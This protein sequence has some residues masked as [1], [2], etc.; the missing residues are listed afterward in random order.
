M[1]AKPKALIVLPELPYPTAGGG[2]LRSASLVEYL[3]ERYQLDAVTFWEEG[4]ARPND[5]RLG[6]LCRR[7]RTIT[8]PR[9]PRSVAPRAA[10]NFGRLWRGVPPL[11]D[12]FAGFEDAIS[13]FLGS[14]T[15]AVSLAEH[16]WCASYGDVLDARSERT[17]LDLHNIESV[18]HERCGESEQWPLSRIHRSFGRTCRRLEEHWLP[19]FSLLLTTSEADA[20]RVRNIAPGVPVGVYPN[21]IPFRRQPAVTS[22]GGIAFSGNMEYH[23]NINAVRWFSRSIWPE[24]KRRWPGMEWKLIGKNQAAVARYVKHDSSVRMTGP[25]E[26]AIAELSAASVAVVPLR[27]GSGTRVKIL[28][29]WAAATPVVSTTVGME[30]LPARAGEHLL[31]ANSP[32]EFCAAVS[33][34]LS[35][36]SLRARVGGAGRKLYEKQ[37]TWQAGWKPL[38][39]LGI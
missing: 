25:V 27:S 19:R 22:R 10:R 12:R 20:T 15:Y 17:I 29:A 18:L 31:V 4:S 16:F 37:F 5:A 38:E 23:P 3:A 26:D 2:A 8:L 36:E 13:G 35:S 28:E 24:L 6:E 39:S 1:A 21:T 11:Y 32:G 7:V 34:L 33:S 30:G 9:H 14:E